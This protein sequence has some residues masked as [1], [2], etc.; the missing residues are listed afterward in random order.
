[1]TYKSYFFVFAFLFSVFCFFFI[2]SPPPRTRRYSAVIHKRKHDCDMYKLNVVALADVS[3]EGT[4]V[5]GF[6]TDDNAARK[7]C[8]WR[9]YDGLN[10]IGSTPVIIIIIIFCTVCEK[11]IRE[12]NMP[13]T[14][15]IFV[16]HCRVHGVRIDKLT[17]LV[18][19]RAACIVYLYICVT[20]YNNNVRKVT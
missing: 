2:L 3:Y 6:I 10:R 14:N 9:F 16:R 13:R 5:N 4:P 19:T 1:M 11:K 7:P 18:S 17:T 8:R 12:V 20:R 15:S